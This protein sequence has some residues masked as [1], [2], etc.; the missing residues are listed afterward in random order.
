VPNA[1]WISGATVSNTV[2]I[3]AAIASMGT[4]TVAAIA[5]MA[6]WTGAATVPRLPAAI[7]SAATS[8]AK[9]TESMAGWTAAAIAWMDGSIGAASASTDVW[10]AAGSASTVVSDQEDI[11]TLHLRRL[12][13]RR[14]Y[15]RTLE[16]GVLALVLLFGAVACGG[17]S[18]G[19]SD[20]SAGLPETGEVT[21]ALTD[22]EGDFLAYLIDVQSLRLRRADGAE[23]SL[24]PER[25][26]IDFTELTALT[27]ILGTGSV[28]VGTYTGARLTLDFSDAEVVVQDAGGEAR[29][30]V[31]VDGDGQ[32]LGTVDVELALADSDRL[33]V[34]PATLRT[35]S[36]DFDLDASNTIDDSGDTPVVTVEPVLLASVGLDPDREHRARGLLTAVDAQAQAFGLDLRPFRR[37]DGGFGEIRVTVTGA[38]G[39]EIDGE[40]YQG[41]A[42]LQALAGLPAGTRLV[43]WGQGGAQGLVAE[44]VL[45]GDSLYWNGSPVVRGVVRARDDRSLSLAAVVL[46]G[47]GELRFRRA[48][49]V[50]V[51]PDTAVAARG[52][53]AGELDAF[54]VSVGSRVL[55][56]GVFD[57]DGALD[58]RD[59]RLYLPRAGLLGRV[60]EPAPLTVELSLLSGLR[61]EA[62]DFAG[63]G[64]MAEEDA[65]PLAYRVATGALDLPALAADDWIQ[66]RGQV[67]RFGFA[68]P[69]F[70]AQSVVDLSEL[71]R[72]ATARVVW[73]E[74]TGN[75]FVSLAPGRLDL[76]LAAAR[77]EVRVRG[78]W[79][80]RV[81]EPEVLSLLAPA[82]TGGRYAIVERGTGVIRLYRQFEA[83]TEALA[84]ALDDGGRLR[85]IVS[86]GGYTGGAGELVTVR[87]SFVFESP[88]VDD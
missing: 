44:R 22:A 71:V 54:D 86:Q 28:P 30:A 23:V 40:R 36:L 77:A 48:L 43:A 64:V 6:G 35:L 29:P 80:D 8:I 65:D 17:G 74:G 26:R 56:A 9:A 67:S 11:M 47:G 73:P 38:T 20:A 31:V 27:E 46:T 60:V 34:T 68:P 57:G 42:G 37:D 32:P 78:R 19:T 62:F 84:A 51:G 1:A 13:W 25:S 3:A 45:A 16:V 21:V 75:P 88:A 12:P 81:I 66:V 2:W 61:P 58:A 5:S 10:T 87:A 14:L 85:R 72:G 53:A 4:S 50:L 63:T 83:L 69:D 76:D 39:Y 7:V 70:Q 52:S 79:R 15:R 41:D 55:A 33:R 24:L 59:G 18:S 49:E 82:A